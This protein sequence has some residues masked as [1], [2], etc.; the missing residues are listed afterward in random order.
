MSLIEHDIVAVHDF[1]DKLWL[2]HCERIHK[3]LLF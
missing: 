1:V 3:Q 2:I